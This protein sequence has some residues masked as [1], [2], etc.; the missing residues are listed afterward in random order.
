MSLPNA[1]ISIDQNSHPLWDPLPKLQALGEK[2]WSG[3]HYIED[4]DTAFT[5]RG[6]MP[7]QDSLELA[8]ERLYRDGTSDWGAALFYSAFIGRAPI[9]PRQLEPY[10]GLTVKKI[11][12]KL[13]LSVDQFYEKYA[14]SDNWQLIGSSYLFDRYSHRVIGDL[15]IGEIKCFLDEL[16]VRAQRDLEVSFPEKSSKRRIGEWFDT[17]SASLRKIIADDNQQS[18]PDFYKKWLR[19]RLSRNIRCDRALNLFGFG[20]K[21]DDKLSG[22]SLLSLFLTD[23]SLLAETYNRA[24]Q[25]TG[26]GV[27]RLDVKNG[28]LPFFSVWRRGGRMFRTPMKLVDQSL[29]C[30]ETYW[31]LTKGKEPPWREMRREGLVSI[32]GKALILVLEARNKRTGAPLALPEQGSLYMPAAHTFQR[33]LAELGFQAAE[34]YPILRVKLSF[35]T[36]LQDVKESVVRPPEYIR[37]RLA[38]DTVET[39]ELARRL[40]E[41]REEAQQELAAARSDEGRE[42]LRSQLDPEADREIKELEGRRRELARQPETRADASELWDKI[43]ALEKGRWYKMTQRLSDDL[44]LSNVD[45]WNSRGAILP[46]SI[47]AGGPDLYDKIIKQAEIREENWYD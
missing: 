27:N 35:L 42:R 36:H 29:I 24:I 34:T 4:L 19:F 13:D 23:Y 22:N 26:E 16:M 43:K 15:K 9:D 14:V 33:Y 28:E 37:N 6:A 17:E 12:R 7:G 45:Y 25:E 1:F 38:C 20:E 18:L 21:S 3:V 46:W 31:R 8:P 32:A 40:A 30:G 47:A 44:H 41:L 39:A 5:R 11:S 10:L 2:G